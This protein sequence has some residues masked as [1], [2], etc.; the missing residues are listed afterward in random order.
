LT[1]GPPTTSVQP[2]P[3]SDASSSAAFSWLSS[4]GPTG[5]AVVG[6]AAGFGCDVAAAP[7]DIPHAAVPNAAAPN[8][9]A[10]PMFLVRTEDSVM[11]AFLSDAECCA[12]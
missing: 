5:R 12:P 2:L 3:Q 9:A 8:T 11:W 6:V 10:S 7:A 1:S 4:K